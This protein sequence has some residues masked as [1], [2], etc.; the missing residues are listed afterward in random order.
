METEMGKQS[1]RRS[2]GQ[3]CPLNWHNLAPTSVTALKRAAAASLSWSGA[4]TGVG[5]TIKGE[6]KSGQLF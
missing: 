6:P 1:E 3:N 5:D 2:D 4:L